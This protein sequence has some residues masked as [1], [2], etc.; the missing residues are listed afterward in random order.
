[1]Q[2]GWNSERGIFSGIFSGAF[3]AAHRYL[4]YR[5]RLRV[6]AGAQR[7][8]GDVPWS[9]LFAAGLAASG[10]A[11]RPPATPV[12]IDLGAASGEPILPEGR[13]L[14][15]PAAALPAAPQRVPPSTGHGARCDLPDTPV[16][17]IRFAPGEFNLYPRG[18]Q[19]L[20]GVIACQKEGLSS[21]QP[22]TVIGYTDPRGSA[23]YNRWLGLARARAVARYLIRRGMPPQRLAV[24]S[25]GAACHL[26]TGPESW[27][28]DRRVEIHANPS[29]QL[30]RLEDCR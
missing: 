1:M 11:A 5:T 23:K 16:E 4:R 14:P 2:T 19:I 7:L 21:D 20:D 15:P 8:A 30:E 29:R 27:G 28:L 24:E 12:G 26:G 10:C 25:L 13:V 17:A 9:L 3:A 22:L 6:P 18:E